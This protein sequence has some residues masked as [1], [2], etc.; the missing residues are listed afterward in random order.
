MFFCSLGAEYL[1]YHF[2]FFFVICD[3]FVS[4]I[5]LKQS[6]K[7]ILVLIDVLKI[8]EIWGLFLLHHTVDLE[9]W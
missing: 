9:F 3:I 8:F 4:Y 1:N 6:W 5:L 2:N 7:F